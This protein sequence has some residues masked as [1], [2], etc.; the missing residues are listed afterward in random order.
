MQDLAFPGSNALTCGEL[1]LALGPA[2]GGGFRVDTCIHSHQPILAPISSHLLTFSHFLTF[3][4]S[5]SVFTMLFCRVSREKLTIGAKGEKRGRAHCNLPKT[6]SLDAR[7]TH[8]LPC[9]GSRA[10]VPL[11]PA[12]CSLSSQSSQTVGMPR[13]VPL[14]PRN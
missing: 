10:L 6:H 4:F 13:P 3:F 8:P 12:P 11:P 14:S 5:A 7:S 2:R 1:A 9:P